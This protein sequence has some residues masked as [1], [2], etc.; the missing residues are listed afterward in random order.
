MKVIHD[1]VWGSNSYYPW[2]MAVLDSPLLQRL[3]LVKQTGLAH[4]VYPT[5]RHSRFDH[6]LGVVSVVSRIVAGLNSK[7]L[8]F[9]AIS[10]HQEMALRMAA[11]LH[12]VGHCILSHIGERAYERNSDYIVA[13]RYLNRKFQVNP[14]PHE[15]MGYYIV[16]SKLDTTVGN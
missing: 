1:P 13:H 15:V 11:I 8:R 12:D 6:T 14:K 3:R 2:E 5:A 16:T 4:L 7:D 9:P 10:R